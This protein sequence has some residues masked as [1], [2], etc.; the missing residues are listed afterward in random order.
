MGT[1]MNYMQ[2]A[3]SRKA[4][5]LLVVLCLVAFFVNNG[6]LR[7]DIMETRNLETAREM[8]GGGS[9]IVPRMNGEYRLEK[10]PLPTWIA[11]VVELA[12]PDNLKA[13]RAM[14]GAAGCM[15]VAFFFLF[16]RRVTRRDDYALT[17]ALMLITCYQIILQSRTATWDIY[18]HAFMMGG[19]YFLWRGLYEEGHTWRNMLIAG[20]LT[21]L[22]FMSK[23]PV[24]LYALLLPWIIAALAMRRP[25]MRGRWMPLV[26]M[27]V[28][29]V[30]ISAWWY[31]YILA[32][33]PEAAQ[34]VIHK[35]SSSWQNHNVRPWW[36]YWRF[37]TETGI[38]APLTLV[39][40][41]FPYW[42]KRMGDMKPAYTA[43]L[44]WTAAQLLLL[45][46]M[47]EKKMRYLLPM[48]MPLCL[49]MAACVAD[50]AERR[51]SRRAPRIVVGV[52]VAFAL[53]EIFAMP[54]IARAFSNPAYHS[55]AATREMPE[56]K[57]LPFYSNSQ[58]QLRIEIVYAAGRIIRPL[59]YASPTIGEELKKRVP[60]VLISR[61]PLGQELATGALAG[62]DTTFIGTYN[63][64]NRTR[65]SKHGSD[66]NFIYNVTLLKPSHN[67]GQQD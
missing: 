3:K 30:A 37:F 36:Y 21:G 42:R 6:L 13:Q 61:K 15:L 46:L 7:P 53:A 32:A 2:A 60:C 58:Q 28:L 34:Y 22:S 29:A 56:L 38:W 49:M 35:E 47:P 31:I 40:L 62:I 50:W 25:Q 12:A 54:A 18:C 8:A 23:G 55:I 44:L 65:F 64:S 16:A 51:N 48:M 4:V 24:S 14:S 10:P 63:N 43:A 17:A 52:A 19:I 59:D 26:A 33:H 9:W 11:A 27:I 5:L 57:G 41:A 67:H 20:A 66:E 1:G 45:S 39:A